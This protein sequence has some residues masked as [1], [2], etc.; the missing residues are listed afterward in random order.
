[1]GLVL[2]LWII[3]LLWLGGVLPG[4]DSP[5]FFEIRTLA[6]AAVTASMVAYLSAQYCDV[7]LFH[8]W[9]WLTN[10][11]HLWL[12]N[13]GSTVVSQLVD[14]TA[15]ILVTYFYANALPIV[16]GEPLWPQLFTF[17]AS[18]WVFKIIVAL[19]DTG[20]IYFLVAKLR[21]YLGLKWNE[22]VGSDD[23][24][25]SIIDVRSSDQSND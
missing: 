7:R 1:M 24:D 5:V 18:L 19:L 8:F 4:T 17:I 9:K 22:E 10:G 13:N 3:F 6:F 14:S 15:V 16:A 12:R 23:E 21:P 20:P 25:I 11:K 2:N